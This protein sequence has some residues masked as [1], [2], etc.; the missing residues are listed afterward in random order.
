MNELM[1]PRACLSV[2]IAAGLA[3]SGTRAASAEDA[4]IGV[5]P[6]D[7]SWHVL[8]SLVAGIERFQYQEHAAVPGAP[9]IDQHTAV[10]PTGQLAV[11]VTAP[12]G[13]FYARGSVTLTGGSM[14]YDGS[15]QD[16]M[17]LTGSTTGHM[18]D[19][20]GDVGWRGRIGR[21]VWLGGYLG[22]GRRTWHRDLSQL[23]ASSGFIEDYAWTRL[24]VGVVVAVAA[25]PRLTFVMDGAVMFGNRS[26]V[27]LPIPS[28]LRTYQGA[29]VDDANLDLAVDFAT[30]LRASAH[31]AFSRH[32]RVTAMAAIEASGFGLGAASPVTIDGKPVVDGNGDPITRAEPDSSTTRL[33]L[34]AGVSYAL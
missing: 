18:T 27:S 10:L 24:P 19:T 6:Q 32:L 11:E 4:D 3:V 9:I 34:T 2:A 22:F 20:E 5:L 16:G 23:P 25:S 26:L 28:S 12:H 33:T 1:R 21:R 30:R 17:P 14:T 15:T 29:P 31:Y 7:D 13:H 8:P